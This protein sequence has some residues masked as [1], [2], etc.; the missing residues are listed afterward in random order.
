[1]KRLLIAVII[2]LPMLAGSAGAADLAPAEARPMPMTDMA[3][4]RIENEIM[5]DAR[6]IP[7]IPEAVAREWRSF[8][9]D[10]SALS[11]LGD[12]GWIA[13]AAL[14]ALFSERGTVRLLSRRPRRRMR[15][16]G[17]RGRQ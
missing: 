8:D 3:L 2:A 12:L 10:G 16:R 6:Q 13:L 1:M 11:V 7:A 9:R 15:V 4:A 5:S 14:V 17:K